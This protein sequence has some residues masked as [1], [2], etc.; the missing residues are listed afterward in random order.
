MTTLPQSSLEL[1]V[2][3]ELNLFGI[4]I[5]FALGAWVLLALALRRASQRTA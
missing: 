4:L 1:P 2:E 3:S 5:V